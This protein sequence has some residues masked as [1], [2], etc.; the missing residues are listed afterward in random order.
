M[1]F[2][3]NKNKEETKFEY[4]NK[5]LELFLVICFSQNMFDI[6]VSFSFDLL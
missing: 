2:L 4:K 1:I 6:C 5:N 3:K